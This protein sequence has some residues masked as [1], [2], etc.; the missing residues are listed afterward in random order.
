MPK[1]TDL[2]QVAKKALVI[3]DEGEMG[4]L[5]TIFL[6]PKELELDY[7]KDIMSAE[8]YLEAKQPSL[9]ILDN[10][11]PDGFGVDFI[12]YIKKKYPGI[13][14]IMISGFGMVRDIALEN[15]ADIFLEKPF[16]KGEFD[17]AVASLLHTDASN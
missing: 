3:E 17:R 1:T 9:I 13:K 12:T 4:L 10:K 11:L 15:G 7:V 2:H 14:I 16:T 5:L 8:A 6:D